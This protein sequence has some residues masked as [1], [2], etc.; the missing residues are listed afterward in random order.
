MIKQEFDAEL[1][2]AGRGGV[3]VNMP[4]DV[5]EVFGTKGRVA[6]NALI[7]GEPYRGSLM[8]MGG[9]C[10]ML[11]V[12]KEIR[13]KIGKQ[14]GDTVH[15]VLEEDTAPRTVEVPQDFQ[16]ALDANPKAKEKFEAMSF[17]HKKEYVNSILEAKRPETRA[18]RI[19]K[20]IAKILETK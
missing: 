20:N 11:G 17:T 13:E 6:V 9:G 10:H 2:A 4:F 7:D 15:I 19:E 12:L 16:S 14:V 5:K 1:I 18:A 8:N 3:Y